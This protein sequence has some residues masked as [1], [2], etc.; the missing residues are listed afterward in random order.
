M[1]DPQTQ[2]TV[3]GYIGRARQMLD[4]GRLTLEHRDFITAV[5]RAYY[6]AFYAANALLATQHLERSK[7]SG[8][9]A[10]FREHFVRTG[11]IAP[12]YS[13]WY[14]A[15]LDTRQRGDYSLE[16]LLD[17]RRATELLEQAGKFV[18]RIERYLRDEGHLE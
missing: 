17:E 16:A 18:D 5:N 13:D 8:V 3:R 1:I 11:V 9:I 7:H 15:L 10:A 2:L 14:G 12:E 4:T 6:A